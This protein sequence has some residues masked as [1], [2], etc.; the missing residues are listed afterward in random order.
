MEQKTGTIIWR[1][2]FGPI[3][4][5]D[6]EAKTWIHCKMHNNPS[7]THNV[8]DFEEAKKSAKT[9]QQSGNIYFLE[10]NTFFDKK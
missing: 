7:F 9:I 10:N 3:Y 5:W 6:K 2:D 8:L 1:N 4:F